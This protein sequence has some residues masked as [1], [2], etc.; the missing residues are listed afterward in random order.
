MSQEVEI[1]NPAFVQDDT[2]KEWKK[3]DKITLGKAQAKEAI[4]KGYVKEIN[5]PFQE[6]VEDLHKDTKKQKKKPA[7]TK[8]IQTVYVGKGN[9]RVELD[10]TKDHEKIKDIIPKAHGLKLPK[11]ILCNDAEYFD[12]KA[13]GLGRLSEGQ[14]KVF[15]KNKEKQIEPNNPMVFFNGSKF[16]SK[17]LGDKILSE[18]KIKTI[19]GNDRMYFYD[20]GYYKEKA[21]E[22]IKAECVKNLGELYE[23]KHYYEIISYIQGST[24]T[25]INE[26]Y[27]EWI[28]LKNG[29]LNPET[30]EFKEHTPEVFSIMQ[31]PIEYNPMADC[32]VW[33]EKLKNKIDKPTRAVLQEF[34]GYVFQPG[35]K[36][37]KALLLHGG[38]RTMKSTSLNVL[39]K[40][41]GKENSTAFSLQRLNE[42]KHAPAYLIDKPLNVCAD[43]ESRGL[44][45]TGAF[46]MMT[47]GDK[48]SAGKKYEHPLHFY[49]PTKLVFSCNDIPATTNKNLAFYRRWIILTFEKQTLETEIDKDLP[50][51][52]E[53][54]L[55][56][57]LNWAIEGLERLNQNKNFSYWLCDEEI[58]DLY[59]KSSDSIQSFIYNKIDIEASEGTLL[60]RVV[61]KAYKKYCK[62]EKLRVENQIKFGK[63][64]VA[65]T[66]CGSVQEKKIPAYRGVNWQNKPTGEGLW[67]DY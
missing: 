36:H 16:V 65:L 18:I 8:A 47:G 61:F 25:N 13:E 40:L 32:P 5:S 20:E 14:Q 4:E 64:F 23:K 45:D 28:N 66:G 24:Y 3:G 33:K 48:I 21:K 35:Q 55:P 59:E 38:K 34:F 57:I 39:E 42:D 44:R 9:Y 50:E 49:A 54:E 31:I 56:G 46:M 37:Q 22:K 27:S 11:I 2:E 30:K 43:L 51:T 60:K 29:L 12:L 62:D 1:I 10:L 53:K 41:V 15:L 7:Q 19:E 26:I 58:K 52:L 67:G 6:W 63:N 17:R